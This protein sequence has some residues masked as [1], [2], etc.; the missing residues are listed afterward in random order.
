MKPI[1]TKY[2]TIKIDMD[3]IDAKTSSFGYF[4]VQFKMTLPVDEFFMESQDSRILEA[5]RG[6]FKNKPN[7]NIEKQIYIE[8]NWIMINLTRTAD[9]M[10]APDIVKIVKEIEADFDKK[11]NS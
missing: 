5:I 4:V 9:K 10:Y 3:L 6:F 8:D 11:V 7:Y 2:T 1:T